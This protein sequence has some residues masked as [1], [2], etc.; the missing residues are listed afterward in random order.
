MHEY[1]DSIPEGFRKEILSEGF[2]NFWARGDLELCRRLVTHIDMTK[3]WDE[4][5]KIERDLESMT[6]INGE[7]TY[8]SDPFRYGFAYCAANLR[9]RWSR[10]I[11]TPNAI[12]EKHLDEIVF[13]STKLAKLIDSYQDELRYLGLTFPA[14]LSQRLKG[15]ARHKS[16]KH[17]DLL[18]RPT[19]PN[20]VTAEQTFCVRAL[21]YFFLQATG[22]PR[23]D[24]VAR[25]VSTVLDL[26]DPLSPDHATKLASDV[27]W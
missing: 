19:K 13:A 1:V 27:A 5:F 4:V 25:T 22:H 16:T 26:E 21:A 2:A 11:K 24:L 20:A 6:D 10:L 17:Q 14:T 7:S 23:F 9:V 18:L 12:I 8:D 15:L 3:V